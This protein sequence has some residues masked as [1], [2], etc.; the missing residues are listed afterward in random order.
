M[1]VCTLLLHLVLIS[2]QGSPSVFDKQW[3]HHQL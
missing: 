2:S 3:S 1:G